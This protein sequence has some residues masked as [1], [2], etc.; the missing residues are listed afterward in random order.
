[1]SYEKLIQHGFDIESTRTFDNIDYFITKEKK[2]I[3]EGVLSK[4]IVV[5]LFRS[6]SGEDYYNFIYIPIDYGE[7]TLI[8]TFQDSFRMFGNRQECDL[9]WFGGLSLFSNFNDFIFSI[10]GSRIPSLHQYKTVYHVTKSV[11]FS[12]FGL[13]GLY[14]QTFQL[15]LVFY[16]S[17]CCPNLDYSPI[18]KLLGGK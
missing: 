8:T 1:M 9:Y 13:T 18:V 4:L 7:N 12:G 3:F 11:D 14:G 6:S 2:I 17:L 15:C 16:N 5:N 10:S